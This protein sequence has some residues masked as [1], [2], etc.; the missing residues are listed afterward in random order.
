M[1]G[2]VADCDG[3]G[4]T[5]ID[6]VDP[7]GDGTQGPSDTDPN[8]PCDFTA[9]DITLSVTA[10]TDCDGD[11]EDSTTDPDDQDPC[12]GGDLSGVSTVL[13]I[14]QVI[15]PLQIVMEMVLLI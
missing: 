11:G 14:Q 10:V 9:S 7:D 12:N 13:P 1:I 4:V 2:P 3:D 15:G 6:E 8:D 5:N